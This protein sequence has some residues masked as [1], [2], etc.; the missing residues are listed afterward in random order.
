MFLRLIPRLALT[1]SVLILPSC[2]EPERAPRPNILLY[3]VDTLRADALGCYGS[4]TAMT[5]AVDA[6]AR[7]SLLFEHATAPS[8]WTRSSMAS[9]F[10]GAVP[11][12]HRTEDRIDS[13]QT[14]LPALPELLQLAG[15]STAFI[16][17]NPN[18]GSFFGFGRGFDE[19]IELYARNVAGPVSS[20]EVV[21]KSDVVNEKAIEWLSGATRPFFLTLLTIDPHHPYSPPP[22][23]LA[24]ARAK[25][26]PKSKEDHFRAM[27]RAE[28]AFNDRSFGKLLAVLEAQQILDDTIVIFTSDHGEEFWEHRSFQH[29]RTL[30][31]EVLRVP[32][33][34]RYPGSGLFEPGRRI[35]RPVQTIDIV[36]TLLELLR[37]ETSDVMD[38]VSLFAEA[39][40]EPRSLFSTLRLDIWRLDSLQQGPWKLI[41]APERQREW[42]FHLGEDP[43]EH[44]P[45]QPPYGPEAQAARDRLVE[46]LAR[47]PRNALPEP[48]KGEASMPDEVRDALR[49]LG[50][51]E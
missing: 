48:P 10:T 11:S 21:T 50:Y 47:V 49:A 45:H 32:L 42:V 6:F 20:K 34:I 44:H 37:L 9:M 1:T 26:P 30:Y 36:P 7:E 4:A 16:T 35:R 40:P 46:A 41:S 19:M 51:A 43:G 22:E 13:F 38:G 27:Y 28:V 12:R 5:P 39:T 23:L 31:E 25:D 17:A 29:G 14:R 15:Y 2:S 8:P 24:A 18:V 33:M 3:V